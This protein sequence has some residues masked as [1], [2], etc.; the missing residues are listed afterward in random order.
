[1]RI[2]ERVLKRL[3]C[4]NADSFGPKNVVSVVD[5][6]ESANGDQS[7]DLT[8]TGSA[9]IDANPRYRPNRKPHTRT[10]ASSTTRRVNFDL[11]ATR[12]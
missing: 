11:P 5:N 1:M 8:D 4:S 6:L 7:C 3:Y 9:R 12:S 2:A 10:A